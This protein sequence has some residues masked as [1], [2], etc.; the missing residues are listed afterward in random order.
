VT[1]R[2]QHLRRAK[3]RLLSACA[4]RAEAAVPVHPLRA[5]PKSGM[6]R[7]ALRTERLVSQHAGTANGIPRLE[8]IRNAYQL[9]RFEASPLLPSHVP[10]R[11]GL[12]RNAAPASPVLSGNAHR[13]KARRPGWHWIIDSDR[14]EPISAPL[15]RTDGTPVGKA[16]DDRE[17][18]LWRPLWPPDDCLLFTPPKHADQSCSYSNRAVTV[19]DL[20]ATIRRTSMNTDGSSSVPRLV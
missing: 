14:P 4:A 18:T 1:D 6:I 10:D 12:Q 2:T 9:P 15:R 20:P 17:R 7:A 11:P 8:Y 19:R 13:A 5:G 16:D 3:G